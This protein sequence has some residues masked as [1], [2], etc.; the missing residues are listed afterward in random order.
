MFDRMPKIVGVTWPRPHP[1]SGKIIC[2]PARHS[3]YKAAYQI[4]SL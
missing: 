4:W 3:P 1:L 2:V